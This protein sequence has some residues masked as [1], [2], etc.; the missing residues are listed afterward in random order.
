MSGNEQNGDLDNWDGFLGSNFLGADDVKDETKPF[1]CVDVE[2][3]TENF[4]PMLILEKDEVKQKF[5]L[6][7]T[8]ANFVK[9]KGLKSP[10][11]CVGKKIFFRKTIAYSPAAKKDV[12]TLR[13][14]KIE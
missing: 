7:V 1:V 10:K 14:D 9:D 11:K 5:S 2:L 3:D 13:I 8:N 12:P 4:R 6:N